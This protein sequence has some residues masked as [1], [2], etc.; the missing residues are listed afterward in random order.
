MCVCA[1]RGERRTTQWI[2]GRAEGGKGGKGMVREV[3]VVFPLADVT[4]KSPAWGQRFWV[5]I[6]SRRE[7][8]K[9]T[10]KWGRQG[11]RG[12]ERG[13]AREAGAWRDESGGWAREVGAC[14]DERRK[15]FVRGVERKERSLRRA[16]ALL[17]RSCAARRRVE[18]T[19]RWRPSRRVCAGA[20]RR[21]RLPARSSPLGSTGARGAWLGA[22]RLASTRP[23]PKSPSSLRPRAA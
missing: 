7:E 20:G 8:K 12:N 5:K 4:A 10:G 16:H 23:F 21:A 3:G 19:A 22:H 11:R 13:R 2:P 14:R 18:R 6:Q 1:R 15:R 9:A 17:V